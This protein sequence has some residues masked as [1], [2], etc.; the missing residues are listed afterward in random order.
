MKKLLRVALVLTTG[1][2]VVAG[3]PA[4][5]QTTIAVD[6]DGFA[7]ATNCG[8]NVPAHSTIQG[9]VNAA[10]PGDTVRVCPGTYTENVD[11]AKTVNIRGARAGVDARTRTPSNESVVHAANPALPTF[12]LQADGIVLKGSSSKGTR[13]TPGS[14][15]RPGSP[16]TSS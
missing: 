7:T 15:P 8:A 2:L 12:M 6:D 11:V 5:A 14:R 10:A 1:A 13:G 3:T 4:R 9:G 16:A